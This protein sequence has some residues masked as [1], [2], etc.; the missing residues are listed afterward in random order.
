M[1]CLANAFS[2]LGGRHE[3][4]ACVTHYTVR[5]GCGLH[6]PGFARVCCASK[7]SLTGAGTTMK[8]RVRVACC[9]ATVFALWTNNWGRS[10]E[11]IADLVTGKAGLWKCGSACYAL[12]QFALSAN[13]YATAVGPSKRFQVLVYSTLPTVTVV[14]ICLC[15]GCV[16]RSSVFF[17]NLIV[18]VSSD[19]VCRNTRA[20]SNVSVLTSVTRG[21]S[22]IHELGSTSG[23]HIWQGRWKFAVCR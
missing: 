21:R 15:T 22:N 23:R 8:F 2:L 11:M 9:A 13:I 18:R 10:C 1:E 19:D 12:H 7:A 6:G 17:G 3:L 5:L 4:L 16:C 20:T 14:N